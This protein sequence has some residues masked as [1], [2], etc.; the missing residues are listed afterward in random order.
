MNSPDSVPPEFHGLLAFVKGDL[1]S[2]DLSGAWPE[3]TIA[4]VTRAI[5]NNPRSEGLLATVLREFRWNARHQTGDLKVWD[6]RRNRVTLWCVDLGRREEL[7]RSAFFLGD[8]EPS[9]DPSF[10]LEIYAV[11]EEE[12]EEEGEGIIRW[13]IPLNENFSKVFTR[14][15]GE[16]RDRL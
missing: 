6:H 9:T 5:L 16:P 15:S 7:S 13:T 3:S 14:L 10:L 2:V 8:P 11:D 1:V 4:L 12:G